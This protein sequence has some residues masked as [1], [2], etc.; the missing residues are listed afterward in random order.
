MKNNAM[1]GRILALKDKEQ[2]MA[3]RLVIDF[4]GELAAIT[5]A[6]AAQLAGVVAI[7]PF[8]CLKKRGV[9]GVKVVGCNPL[10]VIAS[11]VRHEK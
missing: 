5:H 2:K 7:D 1:N 11:E 6:R 8:G 9:K 4:K 3:S 10:A